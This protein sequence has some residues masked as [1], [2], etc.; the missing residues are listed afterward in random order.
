MLIIDNETKHLTKTIIGLD[1]VVQQPVT[2]TSITHTLGVFDGF[3][4]NAVL[5]LDYLN[6]F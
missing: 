1:G 2:F 5:V 6:L 4:Y 3:T